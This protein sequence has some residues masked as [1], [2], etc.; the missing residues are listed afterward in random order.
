M[1]KLTKIDVADVELLLKKIA[2]DVNTLTISDAKQAQVLL[3]KI[4]PPEPTLVEILYSK[5]N[6]YGQTT[7]RQEEWGKMIDLARAQE[8]KILEQE[9]RIKELS[10]LCE[11]HMLTATDRFTAL[12]KIACHNACPTVEQWKEAY[13]FIR[14]IARDALQEKS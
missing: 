10:A 7:A 5:L 3:A 9:V 12:H 4:N 6:A 8:R 14:Q 11:K 2:F 1:T 13:T